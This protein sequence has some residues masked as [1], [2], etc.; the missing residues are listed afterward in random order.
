MRI[1]S[2]EYK[3]VV[4]CGCVLVI[5][6]LSFDKQQAIKCE[7]SKLSPLSYCQMPVKLK[8]ALISKTEQL[9][10]KIQSI[11]IFKY[12]TD[13]YMVTLSKQIIAGHLR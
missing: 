7:R 8:I 12:S 3:I 10:I 1:T 5:V 4:Y 6:Y 9:N 13:F 2:V 11:L